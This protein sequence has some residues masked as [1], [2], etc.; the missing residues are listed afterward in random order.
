MKCFSCNV[1]L[2]FLF[3]LL[4]MA[5][6]AS[7]VQAATFDFQRLVEHVQEAHEALTDRVIDEARDWLRN[8]PNPTM[9]ALGTM[10]AK[11]PGAGDDIDADQFLFEPMKRI[12]AS[13]P[14]PAALYYLALACDLRFLMAQCIDE[15]LAEAV[16]RVD[17]GNFAIWSIIYDQQLE[18]KL[19]R[20]EN[21]TEF[22]YFY[23][24]ASK[25]WDSALV[26]SSQPIRDFDILMLN[27][28]LLLAM[29]IPGFQDLVEPCKV[30]AETGPSSKLAEGCKRIANYL[31]EQ[32]ET[33]I[34]PS[35]G[36]AVLAEMAKIEQS[37]LAEQLQ[38]DREAFQG[39]R[40]CL[41][42]PLYG[43]S[44][45]YEFNRRFLDLSIAH[46]EL[47]ALEII[48]EQEGVDCDGYF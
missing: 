45:D 48:A 15:G 16:D 43:K 32:G 9:Q 31:V 4:V 6:T 36:Y 28:S 12:L 10:P 38:L 44:E 20:L 8:Q 11:G 3:L 42:L 13:N 17:P 34:D 26:A 41:A 14:E 2:K 30:A 29:P 37:D 47:K 22:K 21:S 40:Q 19:E 35:I 39:Y 23:Y 5:A 24:D 27:S 33:L 46:G 7:S 1:I 25:H 18:A